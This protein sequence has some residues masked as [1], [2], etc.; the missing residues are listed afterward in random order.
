MFDETY[1]IVVDM[2]LGMQ[3]DIASMGRHC[4]PR[5]FGHPGH[6]SSIAFCD[7]EH[8][9]VVALVCNGMPGRERHYARLDAAVTAIYTDLGLAKPD[10]TGRAKPYPTQGL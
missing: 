3:V 5:A 10:D 4:S 6:Q 8:D 2:G 7:P 9:V 1:G